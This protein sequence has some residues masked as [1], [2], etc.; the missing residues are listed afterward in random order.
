MAGVKGKSLCVS[1]SKGGV[2]K[3]FIVTSLAGIFASINK[4][5]L[6]IDFDLSGGSIAVSL[7]TPFEK[8]LYNF[9]DDYDN[10]RYK[11]FEDYITHYNQNENIDFIASPKDPRQAIKID[12]RFVEIIL[13]K[14]INNYDI[15]LIDTNHDL[16]EFNI[17]LMDK[18]DQIL[19][20]LTNDIQDIK[21]MRNLI[22]VFKDIDLDYYKI[23]LNN[24]RD[25]FKKYFSMYDIKN[26]LKTNISYSLTPELFL[27]NIDL[28]VLDGKI[29][30]LEPKMKNVFNKDYITFMTIATDFMENKGA[31]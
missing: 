25:P 20:V 3:T 8:S 14:A 26:I 5:V 30:T 7:N 13:D 23:L 17:S 27:K 4:K 22:T 15:V 16:N 2:G 6:I 12:S 11:R 18:V 9:I 31:K 28:Y 24:S 1:S 29:I 21:N 10:N 19:F